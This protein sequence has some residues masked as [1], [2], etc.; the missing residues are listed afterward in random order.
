MLTTYDH[1]LGMMMHTM[2]DHTAGGLGVGVLPFDG[3]GIY[4]QPRPRLVFKMPRVVPDQKSKFENDEL[5]R[6]LS[7]ESEVCDYF[8][9]F[10]IIY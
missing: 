7:R 3:M 9:Y 8:I 6:R 5:F 1:G 4:E 2:S 10:H